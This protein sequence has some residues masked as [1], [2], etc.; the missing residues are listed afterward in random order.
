MPKIS[1]DKLSDPT[2]RAAKYEGRAHKLHDGDGLFLQVKQ[3]GK[4]WHFRFWLGVSAKGKVKER[5]M[6]LGVYPKVS[7]S[8]ARRERD[9]ARVLLAQKNRPHRPPPGTEHPQ[10]GR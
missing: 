8:A 7:L 3:G 9:K 1:R 10:E 2:V 4:Y 6:S 5:L